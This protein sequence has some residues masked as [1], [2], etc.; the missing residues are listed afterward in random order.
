MS[1]FQ[2]EPIFTDFE[3]DILEEMM[4][5]AFGNAAADLAE[6]INLF[7]ELNAPKMRIINIGGLADYITHQ[8]KDF[9]ECSIVEQFYRGEIGG[10][11]FLI[12]PYGVERDFIS[13]FQDKDVASMKSDIFLEL[14]KEILLEVGN[15]LI[16]ACVG[17]L[18]ELLDGVS[19]FF[20]PR[21]IVGEVFNESFI[22]K[23]F[24]KD[25]YAITLQTNFRFE[26][27]DIAGYLFLLNHQKTVGHV[28]KALKKYMEK[29]K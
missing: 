7:I 25:D 11:A 27:R 21:A 28:K 19:T 18:F 22:L 26:D 16:G 1:G 4:N 15:I 20:P 3:I 2:Q 10:A 13:L 14:E 12:F 9:E 23:E 5:I 24:D 6:T 29:Y 8:I 17:K